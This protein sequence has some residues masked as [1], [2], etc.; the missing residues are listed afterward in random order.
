MYCIAHDYY[1]SVP[2]TFPSET[3]PGNPLYRKLRHGWEGN[4][5]LHLR[6]TMGGYGRDSPDSQLRSMQDENMW[7]AFVRMV[8]KI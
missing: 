3:V 6:G 1:S 2:A 7:R 4:M 8:L 5:K